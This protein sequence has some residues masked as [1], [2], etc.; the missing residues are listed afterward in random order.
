MYTVVNE[1]EEVRNQA[2][3]LTK[4][5][6]YVAEMYSDILDGLREH[7]HPPTAFMYTDIASGNFIIITTAK[8]VA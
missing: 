8:Y 7:G 4:S 3:T 6:S 1:W 2:L 5:L